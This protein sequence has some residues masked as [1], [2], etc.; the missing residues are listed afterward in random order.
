MKGEFMKN[1]FNEH[2]LISLL[3]VST[4]CAAVVEVTRILKTEHKVTEHVETV[5][6]TNKT[7]LTKEGQDA[8]VSSTDE[9]ASTAKKTV[10]KKDN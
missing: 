9:L 3:I 10:N 2:P 6:H 4:I 8:K 5:V 7:K 1:L